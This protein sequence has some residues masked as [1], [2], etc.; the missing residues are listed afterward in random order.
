MVRATPAVIRYCRK[1][2]P[3]IAAWSM[4]PPSELKNTGKLRRAGWSRNSRKRLPASVSILPS[5]AIHSLQ[6]GPQAFGSPFATKKIK[7]CCF[8][9]AMIICSRVCADAGLWEAAA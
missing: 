7:G 5:A 4:L 3:I 8:S 2:R 9:L 1:I 6:C